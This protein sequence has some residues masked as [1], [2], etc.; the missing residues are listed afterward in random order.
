MKTVNLLIST[1]FTFIPPQNSYIKSHE[2]LMDQVH[3]GN[4]AKH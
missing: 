4:H 1:V 3:K 2:Q